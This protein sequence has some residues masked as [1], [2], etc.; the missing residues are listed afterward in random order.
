MGKRKLKNNSESEN[1][2]NVRNRLK[3]ISP[4][5]DQYEKAEE[6]T[7]YANK[8]NNISKQMNQNQFNDIS[9]LLIN[10]KE[11]LYNVID[12]FTILFSKKK[13]KKYSKFLKNKTY[14]KWW[15]PMI[16]HLRVIVYIFTKKNR[17]L[18]TGI[19][20]VILSILLF[21]ITITK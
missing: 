2:L 6:L 5:S 12:D 18:Y 4:D 15:I 11:Y 8:L 9:F 1:I 19:L 20:F 14:N 10:F 21:F 17:L 16:D 13:Y 3:L 7:K